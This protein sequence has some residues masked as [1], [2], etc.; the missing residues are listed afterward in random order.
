MLLFYV[1]NTDMISK[2][3]FKTFCPNNY[4]LH[5]H[6]NTHAPSTWTFLFSE[7]MARSWEY[8]SFGFDQ[9]D[10]L[11]NEIIQIGD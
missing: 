3:L 2:Q 10:F 7:D 6:E 5:W 9:V 11:A 8:L 1:D 4:L